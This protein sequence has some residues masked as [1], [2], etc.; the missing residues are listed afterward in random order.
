MLC[1]GHVQ[2]IDG[3]SSVNASNLSYRQVKRQDIQPMVYFVVYRLF[4]VLHVAKINDKLIF[5]YHCVAYSLLIK[6]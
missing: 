5:V 6:H 3:G 2:P 1:L 4:N